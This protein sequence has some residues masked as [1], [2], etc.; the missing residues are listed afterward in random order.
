MILG[1]PVYFVLMDFYIFAFAGWIYESVFC[2]IRN[3]KLVNRGFLVG[4]ILPL[5]GFGAVA[6]YVLLRPFSKTASLLYIMGMIVATVLEYITS[7]LL[8]VLF[9]TKW[10]D[11]TE[12]PY[13]FQGRVALIPSMF[14]GL[15]S[16]LMFD[17]LQPTAT[18]LIELIPGEKGRIFLSVLLVL[19]VADIVYT[20]IATINF[21]K[22]LENLY[23]FRK[24]MEYLLQDVNLASLKELLNTTTKEMMVRVSTR[25]FV[26]GRVFLRQRLKNILGM[27]EDGDSK[28][29]GF[30]ERISSYRERCSQFLKKSPLFGNQRL[31][32]AFPTMKIV[33]KNRSSI[34]VKELLINLKQ[35]AA[36]YLKK[37]KQELQA[38]EESTELSDSEQKE[39]K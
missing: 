15:L 23:E 21:R 13:N 31:I 28:F 38:A 35:K 14:W 17:V 5:Y 30:E 27:L 2:S 25:G 10:W 12:E 33:T 39:K 9:H 6:V 4:P 18:Y 29:A 16:L 11:Y 26:E 3:R 22:Q 7:W 37:E 19:T 1:I 36:P 8:E 34:E 20:V 32:D 24:E